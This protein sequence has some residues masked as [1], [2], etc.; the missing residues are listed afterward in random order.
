[1]K[2]VKAA[3]ALALALT[4]DIGGSGSIIYDGGPASVE[5]EDNGS[6]SA[7]AR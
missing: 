1:M 5:V 6:G 7:A 2:K 4:G 3:A